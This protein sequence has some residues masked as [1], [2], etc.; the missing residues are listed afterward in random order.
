MTERF[1]ALLEPDEAIVYY[2]PRRLISNTAL[3]E[4]I[5]GFFIPIGTLAASGLLRL[6]QVG[7]AS[8]GAA[9]AGVLTHAAYCQFRDW[10]REAA[11]TNHRL[12]YDP[13]WS[14]RR[15]E[16]PLKEIMAAQVSEDYL[17]LTLR[18][19]TSLGLGHPQHAADLAVAVAIAGRLPEPRV[20]L[21]RECR[22]DRLWM[23]CVQTTG[24][25]AAL[26]PLQR[27]HADFVELASLHGL[28]WAVAGFILLGT[29]LHA[30]GMGLGN[31]VSVFVLRFFFSYDAMAGW[32]QNSAVHWQPM[33]STA[34]P[35]Q[36]DSWSYRVARML[37]R[38][39][40]SST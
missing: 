29:A 2:A 7:M 6:D 12:L 13:G 40:Q 15:I 24:I 14:H 3:P 26:V 4:F 36:N 19:G 9:L 30:A 33:S 32:I 35:T 37:Y 22:A 27:L 1:D 25:A 21:T 10:S 20:P 31:L 34:A 23:V 11:V 5:F 39:S 18:D 28:Y 16:L 38:R 17:R 8:L